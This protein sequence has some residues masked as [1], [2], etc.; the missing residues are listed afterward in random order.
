MYE[1]TA[2][3]NDN[4]TI[5]NARVNRP[6][7]QFPFSDVSCQVYTL[8]FPVPKVTTTKLKPIFCYM[9]HVWQLGLYDDEQDVSSNIS[10]NM[11]IQICSYN[12]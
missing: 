11:R 7:T 2:Y 10:L 1:N 4:A 8:L 9:L 3:R 5:C 12:L 6:T